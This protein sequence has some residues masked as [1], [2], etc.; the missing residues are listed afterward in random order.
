MDR[1]IFDLS[2]KVALVTG[3]SRGLGLSIARGLG[4]AGA[5]L[6]LNG[7]DK[8]RLYKAV[9]QLSGESITAFGYDFNVVE[10]EQIC[11][12]IGHIEKEV[13]PIDILVNNAGIQKRAPIVD[14]KESDWRE[15]LDI[16]LT[17]VFLTTQ[18]I[19]KGMINRKGGKIINICSLLS[20]VTRPTLSPYT[21]SKGGLK[22]L[23]RSMAVEWA[24][25]NIQWN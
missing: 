5:T 6:I 8:K 23:T 24:K 11:K 13:G 21:A 7:R 15:V 18:Q 12:N 2:G 25:H 20:E 16:N 22:M 4:K 17:G 9:E 3:S 1:S 10:S 19:V 14:L